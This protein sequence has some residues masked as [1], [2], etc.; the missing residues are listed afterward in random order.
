M[1]HNYEIIWTRPHKKERRKKVE[2]EE[3]ES[4]KKE[5]DREINSTEQRALVI[6]VANGSIYDTN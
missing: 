4:E 1:I 6:H 2:E 3:K 5:R